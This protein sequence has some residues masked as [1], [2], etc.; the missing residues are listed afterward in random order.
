V[1]DNFRDRL[2]PDG[3]GT[4]KAN[5]DQKNDTSVIQVRSYPKPAREYQQVT[6]CTGHVHERGD[7][8]DGL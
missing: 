4:K 3:R 1:W 8:E 5:G 6:Y 2:T 7:R